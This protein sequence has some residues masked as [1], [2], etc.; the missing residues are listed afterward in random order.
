[1]DRPDTSY[2]I[3]PPAAKVCVV[4]LVKHASVKET[5]IVRNNAIIG[6]KMN[7]RLFVQEI[8]SLSHASEMSFI[9]IARGISFI[10]DCAM[11]IRRRWGWGE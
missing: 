1:M 7:T 3:P 8:F 2:Y 9:T 11:I 4:V 6:N 10:R 5:L